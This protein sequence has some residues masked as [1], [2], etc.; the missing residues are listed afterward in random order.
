MS[1]GFNTAARSQLWR[2][3]A[4]F[5]QPQRVCMKVSGVSGAR[6]EGC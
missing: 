5:M 4:W 3:E 6:F 1:F 2:F